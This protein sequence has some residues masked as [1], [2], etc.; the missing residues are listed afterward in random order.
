VTAAPRDARPARRSGDSRCSSAPAGAGA[1]VEE[2]ATAAPVAADAA[3]TAPLNW[4]EAA[5]RTGPAAAGLLPPVVAAG[6]PTAGLDAEAEAAEPGARRPARDT[7]VR[8][9][10]CCCADGF[11]TA[12]TA[13]AEATAVGAGVARRCDAVSFA[14]AAA[15]GT[16]PAARLPTA[17][18]PLPLAA[19]ASALWLLRRRSIAIC[20]GP[21]GRPC[22]SNCRTG[23]GE[24][25]IASE[26]APPLPAATA[27]SAPP[28]APVARE[29]SASVAVHSVIA[30]AEAALAAAAPPTLARLPCRTVVGCGWMGGRGDSCPCSA[31]TAAGEPT[32]STGG[33]A[34]AGTACRLLVDALRPC[35]PAA[36][37]PTA[38]EAE[39]V[40]PPADRLPRPTLPRLCV[41]D[42]TLD[43]EA[44]GEIT[45]A[46]TEESTPEPALL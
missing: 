21:S 26:P 1:P 10:A 3:D 24:Y 5:L 23:S 42:R 20:S 9:G 31:A 28:P 46:R 12:D 29:P 34:A 45:P 43:T 11:P 30:T 8:S 13:A 41:V 32:G 37:A 16:L 40:A 36:P 17:A 7:E 6:T 4:P 35:M 19:A 33:G 25:W 22:A 27:S 38:A 2:E 15:G 18:P 39:A 14:S 44:V